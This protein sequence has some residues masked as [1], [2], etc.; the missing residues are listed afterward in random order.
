MSREPSWLPSP[1]VPLALFWFFY[2]AGQGI[3]FPYYAL[4]LHENAGLAGTE[5]GLV[6][7]ALPL[8]GIF[9]QTFWGQVADRT[10]ARSRV[11]AAIAAS[12]S[13]GYAALAH[14][15]GFA[16]LLLLTAMLALFAQAV[17]PI[18]VS[19]SLAALGVR[20][21]ERFGFVRVWGTIGFLFLV[22]GFPPALHHLQE[23]RGLVRSV[24]GPSEPGLEAMFP[25]TALLIVIAAGIALRIPRGRSVHVRAA[26]GDWR[27]LLRHGPVVRL[28]LFTLGAYLCL[29]GPIVVFPVYV[30]ALGGNMDSIGRM[31]VLMLLLEIPLVALSGAG[32]ARIGARGLL[33]VGTA[34]GG[35]RW[36]I[37]GLSHHLP[38]IY[39]AQLLHGVVVAGLMIGGPLYLEA[40]VPERLRSTG[41]TLLSTAGICF[42]GIL[43]TILAGWL[44]EHVRVTAP[45]LLGGTG[46]VALSL[47]VPWVLPAPI[48]VSEPR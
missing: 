8:M 19:V 7:S 22:V 39:V 15:Q 10:G 37:C 27:L 1:G 21:P 23:A 14:A 25:A 24:G 5:L 35:L 45:Y 20:G 32:L 47:A 11:L 44:V 41:Q 31:W 38:T 46:A 40:V 6:L 29:Q 17:V 13:I 33:A 2:F 42:A 16:Q 26:A 36:V 28:L 3:F 43:S 34:A 12:A 4:Y 48:R 18:G 9:A 30:R